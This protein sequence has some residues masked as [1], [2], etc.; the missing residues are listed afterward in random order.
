MILD[1]G[2]RHEDFSGRR[3]GVIG[4]GSEVACVVPTTLRT[5]ERV[6][7]FLDEPDWLLPGGSA[8]VRGA[9]GALSRVPAL[10]AVLTRPVARLHLRRHVGDP[11]TRRLLTPH[12]FSQRRPGPDLA[13]YDALADPRCRFV[14]WPVYAMAPQGVR[15][16]EGIEHRVDVVVL[17]PGARVRADLTPASIAEAAPTAEI[18]ESTP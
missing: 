17:T 6:T 7:V 3:V 18:Q 12:R 11:W 2:W 10:D 8:P 5:A 4:P 9:L 16:A 1:E 15:T 14:A 13:F